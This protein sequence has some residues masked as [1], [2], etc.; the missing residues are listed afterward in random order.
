MDIVSIGGFIK[1]RRKGL[2][3][4]QGHLAEGLG[5]SAQA[6]SKWE[7]GEN[8]PDVS[9]FPELAQMLETRIEDILNAGVAKAPQKLQ[10]IVDDGLVEQIL[11]RLRSTGQAD[12]IDIDFGFFVYLDGGQKMMIVEA[13]LETQGYELI[14]D[15]ILPYAATT[16]KQAILNHILANRNYEVLEQIM[17]YLS[18]DMKAATLAKLLR[19]ARFDIIEDTITSFNRKHRDMIVDYFVNSGNIEEHVDNF[20]PF[21]DKNQVLKLLQRE[22]E[23]KNDE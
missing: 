5:V 14:L 12:D 18:N 6:V 23:T 20:L 11:A 2:S 10:K 13:V 8:L 9:L 4:T 7:R 21:F 17:V 19:E 22:E 3:M 15:E 1:E 16:H